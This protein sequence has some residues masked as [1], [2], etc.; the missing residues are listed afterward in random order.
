MNIG[1]DKRDVKNDNFWL[2]LTGA[3]LNA[4]LSRKRKQTKRFRFCTRGEPF[5][6]K[7]DVYKIYRLCAQNK[8]TDF[9][10]PTR[11]WRNSSVLDLII[12][13][14]EPLDNFYLT[15]SLDPSNTQLQV[16]YLNRMGVST[17]FFGDDK[18]YPFKHNKPV[19]KCPNKWGDKTIT[20]ANCNVACYIHE[21]TH[22]WLKSH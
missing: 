11:A 16:D 14:L 8:N 15:C 5:S 9:W 17:G 1:L 18:T 10:A 6:L 19:V 13:I 3:D 21:Q 2:T 20:C 22:H 12:N 7:S 4:I